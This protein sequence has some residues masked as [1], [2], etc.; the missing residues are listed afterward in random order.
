MGMDCSSIHS[1]NGYSY[2]NDLAEEEADAPSFCYRSLGA[3][4][5][6]DRPDPYGDN[7]AAVE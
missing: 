7:A 3:I 1:A 4:T 5:C 6:Y 2:C